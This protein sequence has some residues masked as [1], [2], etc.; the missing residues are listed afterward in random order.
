MISFKRNYFF[1]FFSCHAVTS[2]EYQLVMYD[3]KNAKTFLLYKPMKNTS[4]NHTFTLFCFQ[5]KTAATPI[6][7]QISSNSNPIQILFCIGDI[8]D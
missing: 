8:L 6:Q 7:V 2:S 4:Q 1:S 3:R 5:Y